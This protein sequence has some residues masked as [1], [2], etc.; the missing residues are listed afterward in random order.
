[1]IQ[2]IDE[3]EKIKLIITTHKILIRFQKSQ[4]I[5]TNSR[6]VQG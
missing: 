6:E 3:D 4:I 2:R 5:F 1:M